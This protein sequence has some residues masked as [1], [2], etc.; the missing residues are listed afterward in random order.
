MSAVDYKFGHAD[1]RMTPEYAKS[2]GI[3]P[4][5]ENLAKATEALAKFAAAIA[6]IDK[7][8]AKLEAEPIE[9]DRETRLAKLNGGAQ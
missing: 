5:S 3:D 6:D 2:V 8:L 7:R 9:V 1:A 4:A